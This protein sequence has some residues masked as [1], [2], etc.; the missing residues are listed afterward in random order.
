MKKTLL[1]LAL[2]VIS[3][4]CEGEKKE[5]YYPKKI[6]KELYDLVK[7][8]PNYSE[9]T[10]SAQKLLHE[11]T[12]KVDSIAPNNHFDDLPL[13]ALRVKKNPHGKGN[14]VLLHTP[15][16]GYND[17]LL[18]SLIN[19]NYIALIDD[20]NMALSITEG[21]NYK[22]HGKKIYRIN[23]TERE[24]ITNEIY[25]EATPSINKDYPRK[26]RFNLGT[27]VVETDSIIE[28]QEIK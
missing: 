2:T 3:T 20:D 10:L 27:F 17:T 24:L 4:S 19:I 18:S 15:H 21:K 13:T 25:Y 9:N 14:I 28:I 6:D 22:V 12:A 1:L 23:E 26:S 16:Y 7:K 11:L 8:Y 5:T